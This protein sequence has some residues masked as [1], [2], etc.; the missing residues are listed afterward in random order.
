[1]STFESRLKKMNGIKEISKKVITPTD[2]ATLDRQSEI[3]VSE[4]ESI[5]KVVER[6]S[7]ESKKI[8]EDKKDV[9]R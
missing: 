1:M 2:I 9:S 8:S 3:T 7:Y 5:K 6:A 4:I